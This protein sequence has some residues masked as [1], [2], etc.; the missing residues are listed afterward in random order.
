MRDRAADDGFQLMEVPHPPR[1]GPGDRRLEIPPAQPNAVSSRRDQWIRAR[2]LFPHDA[3]RFGTLVLLLIAST[4][5]VIYAGSLALDTAVR[6]LH[7]QSEY[8]VKFSD[9]ELVPP[10]PPWFLG[11]QARFLERVR[12]DAN[13]SEK[14]PFLDLYAIDADRSKADNRDPN[15]PATQSI[16]DDAQAGRIELAF[17]KF[18]WVRQ[19]GRVTYRSRKI[20]VELEYFEPQVYLNW[21]GVDQF[22]LDSAGHLLPVTDLDSKKR[23]LLRIVTRDLTSENLLKPGLILKTADEQLERKIFR[24]M[25]MAT[26]LTT[27]ERNLDPALP[28]EVRVDRIFLDI[29]KHL[30]P[31]P[32]EDPDDLY[33]STRIG[34]FWRWRLPAAEG[35]AMQA[36]LTGLWSSYKNDAVKAFN[37]KQK[38]AEKN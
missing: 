15:R 18:P 20:R 16:S 11:G 19:V 12:E 38:A 4:V 14:I 26:F 9:I 24:A 21:S 5:A 28:A 36:T 30:K 2:R 17:R 27:A 3:R 37:E 25:Q 31:I 34:T 7:Q 33:V 13:E 8:Q 35:N 23:P 22:L 32:N 6:W 1:L 10:P 29:P